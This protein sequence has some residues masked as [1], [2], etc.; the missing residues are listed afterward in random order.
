GFFSSDLEGELNIKGTTAK[1]YIKIM[2]EIGLITQDKNMGR[3]HFYRV[4]RDA[5]MKRLGKDQATMIKP[6]S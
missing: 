1:K 2:A 5:I 3:K 6:Q 4:N